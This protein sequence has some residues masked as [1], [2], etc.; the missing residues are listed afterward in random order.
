MKYF[1]DTEFLEG[2]QDKTLFGFNYGKTKA[3]IDLISIGIVCEDGREFYA[4]SKEFNIKEAWNRYDI[5]E[6]WESEYTPEV[7]NE[8]SSYSYTQFCNKVQKKD[9]WV[10]ENVLRPIFYELYGK[11]INFHNIDNYF[12]YKEFKKLINKYG[13]TNKQIAEGIKEF[14]L[15][16]IVIT[17]PK[18]GNYIAGFDFIKGKP[19]F[20]AYYADYDWVVFCWLFGK[21]IDLP[22]S[23]PMYCND[24]K[25][26]LDEKLKN[27]NKKVMYHNEEERIH[28]LGDFGK[29]Y[30]TD[31]IVEREE[32]LSKC[33]LEYKLKFIE[34]YHSKYP[35]QTNEHNAL[36]DAQWNKE[37]YFFLKEL[38][39]HE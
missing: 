15:D 20:Y 26:T 16:Q 9:Y 11:D 29:L 33:T 2:T 18:E 4:I 36:A 7:Y 32:D 23:F 17:K 37:L 6:V 31:I 8:D 25:Q 22:K 34:K 1:L 27:Y 10:R 21:M 30:F 5:K 24:L 12:T 28:F 38:T 13:K 19:E 14:C 39:Q 3:T 35:K